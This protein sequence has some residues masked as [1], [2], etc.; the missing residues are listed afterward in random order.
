MLK[1]LLKSTISNDLLVPIAYPKLI[2][3]LL[4]QSK[5]LISKVIS[6]SIVTIKSSEVVR[7]AIS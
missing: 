2:Q 4:Y 6:P 3:I 1:S 5:I 7:M